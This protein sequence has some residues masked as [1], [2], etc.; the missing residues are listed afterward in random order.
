M[1]TLMEIKED[2]QSQPPLRARCR[3]PHDRRQSYAEL[4]N[5]GPDE[6]PPSGRFLPPSVDLLKR[7][8]ATSDEDDGIEMIYREVDAR[9]RQGRFTDVDTLLAGIDGAALTTLPVVYLLAFVSITHAAA[10][11]LHAR[12]TFLARVR[13]QI[14]AAEPLAVD[15]LL[16]GFE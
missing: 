16:A 1:P 3:A 6:G 8:L 11:H 13:A 14:A 2:R 15:E 12:P 10:E 4:R 9:L 7:V 5:P